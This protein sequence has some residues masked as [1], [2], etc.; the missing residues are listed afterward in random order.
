MITTKTCPAI[1]FTFV[2]LF[3]SSCSNPKKEYEPVQQLQTTAEQS[4]QGTSDDAA[5]LKS[6]DDVIRA[7]QEFIQ[8]HPEGEWNTTA[9]SAL[10]NWQSKRASIQEA[11]NRKLDFE[12]VQKLQ[13]AAEQVMQH[14][15]DYVVWMK[16]CDD[17]IN[18]LQTYLTKHSEG[19]WNTS[20]KTALMSWQSRKSTLEQELSTLGNKL[21]G[22][23]KDR[24][25]HE[26]KSRHGLSNI[27]E[28]RLDS[29]DKKTVGANIQVTDVYAIRMRGALLGTSIFKLKV[30]V[31]GNIDPE[32]KRVFVNENAT[33][34]E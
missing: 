33:V 14:S 27:E 7:L 28:V 2:L 30:T 20:A 16:S 26:A 25:M 21:F 23:M 6:C 12:E 22:M 31:S 3:L 10:G 15:T 34:E 13:D 19:E 32:I 24:A 1:L 8:N 29:R 5:K 17:M 11:V 4:I 9:K 18:S